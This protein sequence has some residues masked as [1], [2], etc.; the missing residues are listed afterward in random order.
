MQK[1][2]IRIVKRLALP[3]SAPWP[4]LEA[5]IINIKTTLRYR[6]S[7]VTIPAPE[8][9][10]MKVPLKD[11][12]NEVWWIIVHLNNV[13]TIRRLIT[14]CIQVELDGNAEFLFQQHGEFL[15]GT[16]LSAFPCTIAPH[17]QTNTIAELFLE[18]EKW[19][20]QEINE[21]LRP[22][23]MFCARHNFEPLRNF[24]LSGLA[25]DWRKIMFMMSGKNSFLTASS[26]INDLGCA[27]TGNSE[28]H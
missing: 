9:T 6:A 14:S 24:S 23:W 18:V 27:A 17:H 3:Q 2:S 20:T 10:F 8:G 26:R 28:Y 11:I 15:C 22:R 5:A 4:K 16:H 12:M 25:L 19:G 1:D 7:S 21:V 13:P